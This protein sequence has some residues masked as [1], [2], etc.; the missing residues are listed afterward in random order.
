MGGIKWQVK[1]GMG[2]KNIS[3]LQI[4]NKMKLFLLKVGDNFFVQDQSKNYR[5]LRTYLPITW[6]KNGNSDGVIFCHKLQIYV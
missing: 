6:S 1:K 2:N 4:T 3:Y 5:Y